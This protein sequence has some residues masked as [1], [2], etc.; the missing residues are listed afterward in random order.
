MVQHRA[1]LT[2][3]DQQKVVYDLSNDAIY[4]DLER[5]LT[6]VLQ[7]HHFFNVENVRNGTRYRHSLNEIL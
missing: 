6:Q 7:S 1:I 2:M 3:D 4:N 5:P